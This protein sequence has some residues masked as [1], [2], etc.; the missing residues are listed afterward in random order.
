MVRRLLTVAGAIFLALLFRRLPLQTV[1][2]RRAEAAPEQTASASGCVADW[3]VSYSGTSSWT[4]LNTDPDNL[5]LSA[6]RFSRSYND[7]TDLPHGYLDFNRD[8][9]SDIFSAIPIGGLAQT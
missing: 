9:K 7:P 2:V 5:P 6:L 8:G 3:Y 1:I 4:L